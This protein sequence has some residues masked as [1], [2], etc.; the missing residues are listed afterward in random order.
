MCY[1][2][3]PQTTMA[4]YSHQSQQRSNTYGVQNYSYQSSSSFYQTP[5]SQQQ[6]QPQPQMP[7]ASYS[8][9]NYSPSN[10][11]LSTATNLPPA[12]FYSQED[13]LPILDL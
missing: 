1:S 8:S 13:N 10:G 7:T 4:S 9:T 11:L 5:T 12:P 2:T 6:Q 3:A